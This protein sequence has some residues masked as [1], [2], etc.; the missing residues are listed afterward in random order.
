MDAPLATLTAHGPPGTEART[1][2]P[3]FHN[4]HLPDGTQ[5]APAH[6]LGDFPLM[7]WRQVAPHVPTELDGC[8]VLDIGC[9][10][11]FYSFELARRGARVTALDIDKRYLAQARWAAQRFGLEDRIDFR[12]GSVYSLARTT[13]QYDIVWFFGVLYHL[14]HPLLALDIVRGIVRGQLFLQTM[15]CPGGAAYRSRANLS[16][17]ERGAMNRRG[18]PRMAFIENALENDPTN[19]WAPNAACVEGMLRAAGFSVEARPGDEMY[20]ATPASTEL[21]FNEWSRRSE[22]EALLKQSIGEQPT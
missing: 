2:G 1:L 20:V 18:W 9:N 14:R 6:P 3:W 11:G 16:L 15:T 5:T 22:L 19:W 8:T 17:D 13:S 7:K 4:L 12:E 21:P 10:A